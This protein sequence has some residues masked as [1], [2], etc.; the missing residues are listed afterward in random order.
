[1]S[2]N[3]LFG[4]RVLNL[5]HSKVNGEPLSAAAL[6][7][8]GS[9]YDLGWDGQR[10]LANVDVSILPAA[11][12]ATYLIDAVKFHCGHLFHM[13]DEKTF[14]H[15][16]HKF[17]EDPPN[18]T[19][20]PRLWY[21]HFL[22]ILAFGKSFIIRLRNGKRPP[23]SELFVQAMKL[24]PDITYMYSDAVQSI[25][26]LC[27]AALYLQCL[28]NRSAAY[29]TVTILSLRTDR[30]IPDVSQDRASFANGS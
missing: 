6:L 14:M 29:N 2:S 1:M 27:C 28:D 23:G 20:Y 22:I 7:F 17:Y 3:W 9:T 12:F 21:I 24:L 5:V 19:N 8:E 4:R 25:E 13:F 15:H 10:T 30:T 11:D 16:L 26:I 18:Q